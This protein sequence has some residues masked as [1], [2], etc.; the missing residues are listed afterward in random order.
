VSIP[1]HRH[2]GV[3]PLPGAG[4]PSPEVVVVG[5][6]PVGL[7]AALDLGR[8]GHRV[9]LLNRLPFISAGSKAI[10]FAHQTLNIWDRLGVGEQMVERGVVWDTGKVFVGD[11]PAPVYQFNLMPDRHRKNPAFINLPQPIAEDVLVE[12]LAAY[13]NV[14]FRWGHNVTAIAPGADKVR[15]EVE[16]EEGM[17]SVEA[18]WAIAA[19]GCRSHVRELLGLDFE[20]QVFEDNFLIADV[21]AAEERPSERWFWFDPPFNRGR[22]ALLHKQPDSVWRLDFQIGA[23]ADRDAWTRPERVEPLVR[24]MLGPDARFELVWTSVYTFQCRR[25]A[26]FVHG[27]VLFAGDAAHLVSPF[28]ARGCNNGIADADNL[29]W[30]LSSVLTGDASEAL[31]ETYNDEMTGA[32]DE[33]ILNST[34]STNFMTASRPAERAFRDAVLDLAADHPFAR[35]FVNSGRLYAPA[36][37]CSSALSTPDRDPWRNGTAPGFPAPDAPIGNDWLLSRLEGR[38]A[39][40]SAGRVEAPPAV[41]S[42]SLGEGATL[43]RQRYDLGSGAAVLLRPDGYVAARWKRA[44]REAISAGLKRLAGRG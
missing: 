2:I 38:P 30:K 13:P 23:G 29:C 35:P 11:S 15:L 8:R 44:D 5:G 43:A 1:V 19:D 28:G 24:G 33:H 6:G 36:A 25:M 37:Y 21:R 27:R 42:I 9:L 14:E 41:Q 3:T 17:Y 32:A 7:T 39:L 20:G 34:R 40:L 22:S 16:A 4:A 18:P 10:C 31:I 26:R 12:A